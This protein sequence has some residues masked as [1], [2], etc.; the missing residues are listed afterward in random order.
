MAGGDF[1]V[2]TGLE[3][4]GKKFT[5]VVPTKWIEGDIVWWPKR[6][7]PNKTKLLMSCATPNSKDFDEYDLYAT[8]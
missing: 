3:R 8:M 5:T 7:A 2:V 1:S 6:D 4:D